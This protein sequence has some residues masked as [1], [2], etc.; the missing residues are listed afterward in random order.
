MNTTNWK[1]LWNG[2]KEDP[3]LELARASF[4]LPEDEYTFEELENG[5][6]WISSPALPVCAE[7]ADLSAVE[8]LWVELKTQP[9]N[10][11]A[12]FKRANH[13]TKTITLD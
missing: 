12:I 5:S 2:F 13:K 3:R 8:R 10:R 11:L 1:T 7:T 4:R 6:A 9:R